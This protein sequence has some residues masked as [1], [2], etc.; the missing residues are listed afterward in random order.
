VIDAL[1]S[2]VV[3]M[4][5]VGTRRRQ[6]GPFGKQPH[7]AVMLFTGMAFWIVLGIVLYKAFRQP[8]P[9]AFPSVALMAQH[10]GNRPAREH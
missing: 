10:H 6:F 1:V 5:F 8:E 7:S 4:L 3:E 9:A 2:A